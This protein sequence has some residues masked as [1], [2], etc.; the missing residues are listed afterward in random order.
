MRP[1]DRDHRYQVRVPRQC[2]E[3]R[4]VRGC[5]WPTPR[6][7]PPACLSKAGFGTIVYPANI[8]RKDSKR[9]WHWFWHVHQSSSA[10]VRSNSRVRVRG[11]NSDIWKSE[12]F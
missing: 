8:L 11:R 7:P 12:N 4:A 6:E 1:I 9:I 5:G 3:N 2:A 10:N